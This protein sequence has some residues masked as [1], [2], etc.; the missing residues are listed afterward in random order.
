MFSE[1]LMHGKGTYTWA[2]G[3]K[4]EGN[5]VKNVQMHQ[6]R[7]TWPDGSVYDGQ[8]KSGIRHGF[9][10]YT[11]GT[12]P[13]S[14]SG[15][16][17]EGKR[18]GKGILYYNKEGSS[19]YEGQFVNN[20]K[21]GWGLRC[22]KSGNV[23]KGDWERDMRHGHGTM[24][25]LTTDQ[26]YTGQW[27][28]GLQHGQGIHTWYLKRISGSQY[29]LRN[30]YVGDIVNGNRH[31]HGKFI[32]ASGAVYDGEWVFNKKHGMGKLILKNGRQYEGEFIDDRLAKY[33]ALQIDDA[34]MH[35][36]S[37]ICTPSPFGTGE[38][39]ELRRAAKNRHMLTQLLY[40]T[41]Q[42]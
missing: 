5:F 24:S 16:W 30:Q 21:S 35:K 41:G 8:V 15:Q 26:E 42:L 3:V 23:Y 27:V 28:N 17:F 12:H 22:Y 36:L 9:G 11:C 10:T 37:H 34:N 33:P 2:D 31:G 14:Y 4:Y 25:W 13:I 29:P 18:H 40:R 6:G 1:G 19:W 39:I 32:F 7:Y 20:V 38:Q